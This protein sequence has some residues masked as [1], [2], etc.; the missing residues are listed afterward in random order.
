MPESLPARLSLE[1]RVRVGLSQSF[2]GWRSG[3]DWTGIEQD[4][5][6]DSGSFLTGS[7]FG[8]IGL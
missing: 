3:I 5:R 6:G 8:F 7:F 4:W 1:V 2:G